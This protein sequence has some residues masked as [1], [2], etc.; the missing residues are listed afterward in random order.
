MR[1][2][3]PELGVQREG[4]WRR[5]H[6]RDL[7]ERLGGRVSVHGFAALC[8]ALGVCDRPPRIGKDRWCC[9][10]VVLR[11][12]SVGRQQCSLSPFVFGGYLVAPEEPGSCLDFLFTPSLTLFPACRCCP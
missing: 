8:R 12:V 1:P 4:S 3:V 2:D 5:R 7:L 11:S 6:G 10:V 9:G